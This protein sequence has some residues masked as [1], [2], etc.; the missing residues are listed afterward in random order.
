MPITKDSMIPEIVKEFPSCRV[1]FDRYGLRGCGGPEGPREPVGWFARLHGVPLDDLLRELNEAATQEEEGAG[2]EEPPSQVSVADTIYQPFFKAGSLV[3]VAFGAL[4]GAIVLSK[5]G[6]SDQMQYNAPYGW[7][8]AHAQVMLFGFV[9]LFVMGFAYQALPR[10]KH[11]ELWKPPLALSALPLMLVGLTLQVVA[12]FFA[13]AP[14][15]QAQGELSVPLWA[16]IVGTAGAVLQWLS[17][18]VFGVVI[19]QTLQ[20]AKKREHY[21]PLI[22]A[23][24][25]W[26]WLSAIANVFLFSYWG[27]VT[28]VQMFTA[29]IAAFNAPLRDMQMYGFAAQ[30][31][32][33]IS[34]RFLPHAY[35]FPEPSKSWSRWLLVGVNVGVLMTVISFPLMVRTQNHNWAKVMGLGYAILFALAIAHVAQM[36]LFSPRAAVEHDR[37]LKFIRAAFAWLLMGLLM[38]LLMRVYNTWAGQAFSHNYFPAYR[39]AIVAGFILL[40]IVGVSS[41]VTP[42]LSGVDL[43]TANPL[44]TAFLLLNVGNVTRIVGQTMMDTYV[45]KAGVWAV[46]GGFVQWAG[47]V[48]WADDLWRTMA[49]S[50]QRMQETT[51]AVTD[52]M[53]QT[54]VADVLERYPQTLE[55]FLRHGFTPLKNPVLRKTMAKVVTIEIACRREGVDLQ[56]LLAEL[57][58][59]AGLDTPNGAFTS[60]QSADAKDLTEILIWEALEKCHDPE[61]PQA[62]IVELGLIYG[63][64]W[65]A[66]TGIAEITM[67]LTSPY[68]PMGEQLAGQAR[69]AV[70]SVRGVRTANV[71]LTFQPPWSPERIAPNVREQLGV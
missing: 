62:N 8:L 60:T 42:T 19:F 14:V 4:W 23:A 40:M 9:A 22:F 25:G 46:A 12:H 39:H 32:L 17:V 55:I 57:R 5:I 43:Q 52:I 45:D 31:I 16:L 15:F 29:R 53:P 30:L 61:I 71:H 64:R 18:T 65:D 21:D 2:T 50:K 11:V 49:V 34:L 37:A 13:P 24:I 68:C 35:G 54:K 3:A 1:V 26:F 67:T 36:K 20:R 69:Q 51:E 70:E 56:N 38:V 63:V 6:L 44:W 48:L 33:G 7:T 27:S 28:T 41:K 58:K 66:K 10:F 47:M 59:V